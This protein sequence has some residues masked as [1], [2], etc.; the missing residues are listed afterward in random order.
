[1]HT[2]EVPHMHTQPGLCCDILEP[3][4]THHPVVAAVCQEPAVAAEC[5]SLLWLK[6]IRAYWNCSCPGGGLCA[7]G[8]PFRSSS[9]ASSASTRMV[10]SSTKS[11]RS[12]ALAIVVSSS[13]WTARLTGLCVCVC[14][15]VSVYAYACAR[16]VVRVCMRAC[17]LRVRECMCVIVFACAPICLNVFV[18]VCVCVRACVHV[19]ICVR[20]CS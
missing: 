15:R 3:V 12:S 9:P 7:D 13:R 8:L 18:C 6:C 1:M 5:Q 11:P 4:Y 20:M 2:H 16:Y 14:A 10:S 19:C 17:S